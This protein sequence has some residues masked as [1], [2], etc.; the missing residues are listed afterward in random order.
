MHYGSGDIIVFVWQATLQDH[1]IKVLNDFMVR[2]PSRY[3]TIP[4]PSL[5][6][7]GTMAVEV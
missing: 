2:S 4:L 7:I 1:I 6:A 5:L 3:V